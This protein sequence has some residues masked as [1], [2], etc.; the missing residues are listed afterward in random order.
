MLSAQHMRLPEDLLPS[1]NKSSIQSLQDDTGSSEPI[2]A[3]ICQKHPSSSEN[4]CSF[5]VN[6]WG[7]KQ[8]NGKEV[9][10]KEVEYWQITAKEVAKFRPCDE[11]FIMRENLSRN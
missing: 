9:N 11:T 3:E 10:K 5:V 7:E 8:L 4:N 6:N 2:Y 1:I